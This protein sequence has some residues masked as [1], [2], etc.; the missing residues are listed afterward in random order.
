MTF[1]C[2]VQKID[3]SFQWIQVQAPSYEKA[4]WEASKRKDVKRVLEV[5]IIPGGQEV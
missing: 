1:H 3:S 2:N 5:S 4:V